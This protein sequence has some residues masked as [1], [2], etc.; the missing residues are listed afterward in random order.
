MQT[1]AMGAAEPM[2]VALPAA[3]RNRSDL[4]MP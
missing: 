2:S 3:T 1:V 4:T